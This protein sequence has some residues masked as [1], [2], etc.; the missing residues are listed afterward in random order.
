M[1]QKPVVS[2]LMPVYNTE[3]YVAQAVKSILTQTFT[4]FELIIIDDGSI[5]RSLEIMQKYAAK[6]KRI[7]LANRENRGISRTRNELLAEAEGEF[8][9]L[10]DSDDVAL[11]ERL[12]R[13]VE[14][15]RSR[16][17]VLCVGSA[18][19]FIDEK[20]NLLL[21]CFE[22]ESSA[23][24]QQGLLAG[25][26][27]KML[28][29]SVMIR[30]DSLVEIGSY[31]ETTLAEDLDMFLRLGEVGELANLKELLMKYRIRMNSFCGEKHQLYIKDARKVCERAW[32]RRGIEGCFEAAKDGP[33]RP[34]AERF[35]QHPF[36]VKYGW[37]AFNSGQRQTA[38]FYAIRAIA[39]LPFAVDGWKLLVCAAIKPLPSPNYL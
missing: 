23:E 34:K 5:D 37:W 13:Q 25:Y 19:Q 22:P 1:T 32:Q 17:D 4:D 11:P 18:Y 7:R 2:V 21:N 26:A 6:D 3:R 29:P 20:G 33:M 27:N 15:L 31:D 39:A 24:I 8:I 12:T 16:P 38:I 36:L 9:A 35:S 30:R 28:Q 10:M 14:F